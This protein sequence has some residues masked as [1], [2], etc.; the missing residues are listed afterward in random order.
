MVTTSLNSGS[1]PRPATFQV[2]DGDTVLSLFKS[3]FAETLGKT[4]SVVP[5]IALRLAE[6]IETKLLT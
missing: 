1:S 3:G 5:M 4:V 6:D 2:K